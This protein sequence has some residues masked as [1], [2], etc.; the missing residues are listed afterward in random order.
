MRSVTLRLI[1]AAAVLVIGGCGGAVSNPVAG[2]HR[3]G[4]GKLDAPTAQ[5][6]QCLRDAR[7]PVTD[8]TQTKIQVGA[9]PQG[10]TIEYTPTPGAGQ[11]AQMSGQVQAA[12]VIG[13]AL[14]YP[15]GGSDAELKKIEDCL[16]HGVK[17]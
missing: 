11:Q 4:R 9:L 5:H 1:V 15:N 8:V 14:L 3:S 12:E 10:P 6:V 17:G 13:G 2:S 16:A 7:L